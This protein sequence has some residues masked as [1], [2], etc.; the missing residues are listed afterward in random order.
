MQSNHGVVVLCSRCPFIFVQGEVIPRRL[1][2]I[3]TDSVQLF[4]FTQVRSEAV[5]WALEVASMSQFSDRY[6][7]Q[8]LPFLFLAQFRPEVTFCLTVREMMS[9]ASASPLSV[10]VLS[11]PRPG[12]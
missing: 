5:L 6:S 11:S 4:F 12:S 8:Y 2:E 1:Y 9:P 3:T 10:H 7:G